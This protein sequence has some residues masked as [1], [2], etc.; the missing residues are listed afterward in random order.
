MRIRTPIRSILRHASRGHLPLAALLALAACSP[1]PKTDPG[2]VKITDEMQLQADKEFVREPFQDQ[3]AQGVLRQ[4]T[5]FDYQFEAGSAKLTP[6]GQRD[7]RILAGAMRDSGG[8]ISVRQG[9][10]DNG[11]Y[12]ARR[13]TVRKA[14]LAEGIAADRIQIDD[15][16]PGGR[17]T[18]TTDAL[19]I[20]ERIQK[21][22]MKPP[23]KDILSPAGST[24]GG[25]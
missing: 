15:A 7:V 8:S 24:S 11:L 16:A 20:R 2:K 22:P 14:L 9:A 3:I 17:G 23:P 10:A 25:M 21:S 1:A 6:L 5:I 13:D 19:T 18:A 12:L 4:R